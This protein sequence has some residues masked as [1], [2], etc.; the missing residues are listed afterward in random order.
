MK[1]FNV[2]NLAINLSEG[3]LYKIY[4]S[5]EIPSQKY[6]VK[7]IC[8][9]HVVAVQECSAFRTNSHCMYLDT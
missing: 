5:Q 1:S 8:T 2:I 6:K 7:F 3:N 9:D 4:R